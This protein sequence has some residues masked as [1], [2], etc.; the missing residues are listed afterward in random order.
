MGHGN[1]SQDIAYENRRQP[2]AWEPRDGVHPTLDP[3]AGPREV[4]NLTPI[5]VAMDVTRSRGDDTRRLYEQL[6]TLMERL[7]A[8]G[9]AEN[10][11]ISFAAIGDAF[12]DRAPLQ[13]GQ[14]EADNRLDAV[15]R[16]MWIEEG[17]GGTGQESYELAALYY[18][19]TDCV[20]LREGHAKKGYFIFVGDEGFYPVVAGAHRS[21]LLGD[22][23][24]TDLPS[25]E[26]FRALQE[27][28]H[29]FLVFP[30]K[31]MEERRADIDA[32]IRKRV[33]DAGGQYDEVDVRF[34]LVWDNRNDLDL[35]VIAPSGERIF[36]G[37]KRSACGGELDVDRNV[38][39]ETTTPV[40]NVR[41]PKGTAPTGDYRVIV[42]NYA[43]HEEVR[44]RTPFRVE[45]EIDGELHYHE[46][47]APKATRAESDR[48]IGTFTF[49]PAPAGDEATYAA[50]ADE[51][52][53]GQWASV[54]P[55]G[56]ILQL[57][58]ARNITD[59]LLGVLALA[60]G[61]LDHTT[62]RRR[63][64][65]RGLDPAARDDVL[66]ALSEVRPVPE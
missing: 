37:H 32:E 59:V 52:V 24:A 19:R 41:W 57:A 60:S 22:A 56:H 44:E 1:Y 4:N 20:A 34:T 39:G 66:A 7:E 31:P 51:T 42:Q 54:L 53:L 58:D 28:F 17:G 13:V 12:S 18:S 3:A 10:P 55:E 16:S 21:S 46:G 38:R 35:H 61:T 26:A 64:D 8:D 40:E 23:D 6:P 14:F 30:K 48:E 62:L 45:I 27:R 5:V 63:L 36:F 15:I 11:G 2:A 29:V 33:I 9:I 43:F 49:D 65:E 25:E 47:F 50:Y